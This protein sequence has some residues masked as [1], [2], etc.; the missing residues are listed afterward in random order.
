M[1]AFLMR[2]YFIAYNYGSS[3]DIEMISGPY[4][5]WIEANNER[6]LLFSTDGRDEKMIIVCNSMNVQEI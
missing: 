2:E 4:G 6:E 3:H 1:K 5:T